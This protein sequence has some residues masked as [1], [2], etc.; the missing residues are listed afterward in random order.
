[1]IKSISSR[2]QT[3]EI[4][5][6]DLITVG[7]EERTLI[8]PLHTPFLNLLCQV[9]GTVMLLPEMLFNVARVVEE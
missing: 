3:S 9:T 4:V 1:M 2:F 6:N 8:V 5:M 7:T